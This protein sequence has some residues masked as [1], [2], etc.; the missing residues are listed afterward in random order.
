MNILIIG[1]GASG[2]AAA[3]TAAGLGA[4]VTLA[5][6][7]DRVGKKLLATGNGR[8]NLLNDGP[9]F[10]YHGR[11][12][13]AR[14]AGSDG[15]ARVRAFFDACGLRVMRRPEEDGRVYPA[16]GQASAVCDAL[17]FAC[18]RKGV[19]VLTGA[20]VDRVTFVPGK[21]FKA[22]GAFGTL[23][24]DRVIF[25]CGSPAGTRSPAGSYRLLEDL[26]HPVTSLSPALCPLECDMRGLGALKGLRVPAVLTLTKNGRA[27]AQA[28]GE[29]L[30]QDYG[31]SGICAMQL[32]ADAW[33]VLPGGNVALR[34]DFSPLLDLADRRHFHF[35]AGEA[36]A[37]PDPLPVLRLLEERLRFLPRE[38]L[39]CGLLPRVLADAA[40]RGRPAPDVL[41]SRLTAFPIPVTGVRESAAQVTRGGMDLSRFDPDTLESRLCPGLYCCGEM[42][43]VDGDCGGFNLMFA[44]LSGIRAG[45][46]A[47]LPRKGEQ[48]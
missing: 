45:E 7:E 18:E 30:F 48:K 29:C 40:D 32:S 5:E 1:G 47:A 42:L 25:A 35:G 46:C 16:C 9:L 37:N 21:G 11:A 15:P 3:V 4:R 10:Y 28:G 6:K 23:T 8:C 17:R 43:D 26:G 20:R 41:A 2:M 44:F 27:V 39:L 36:F 22:Q 12:L 34:L 13:A 24:G 19:T 31:I 33:D 14:L 38:R